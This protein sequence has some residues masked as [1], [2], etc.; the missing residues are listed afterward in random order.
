LSTKLGYKKHCHVKF[1]VK[2]QSLI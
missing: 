1:A 2:V